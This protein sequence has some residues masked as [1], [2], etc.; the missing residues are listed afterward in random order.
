MAIGTISIQQSPVE[1]A[2]QIPALTNWTPVLPYTVRQTSITDLFYFKFILEIRLDDASGELLAK[3]KQRPNGYTT[4]TT[5]VYSVFNVG[6]IIN[7]QLENT[8]ADQND[9][10]KSIHTLGSNVAAEIFSHN[11][12]QLREVYVKAYQEYSTG[13]SVSPTENTS[14][15]ATNT[16]YYIAGTLPLET[17]RGTG[18]YFQGNAFQ[19]FQANDV[20]GKFLSDVQQSTGDV[21][22]SSVYRNYVQWDD[23]TNT[24]DFHTLGFLNSEATFN[25]DIQRMVVA[26][27]NS[28]GGLIDSGIIMNTNANG[29][30]DPATSGGEA[31]TNP[32]K[33][34]YFGCGPGNLQ[35]STVAPSGGSAGD[36]RPSNMS[37]WAYYTVQGFADLGQFRTALYY[38][39]KQDASCKGFKIRRLGWRNS[40]GCWDYFNFKMKSKQNVNVKRSTYGQALGEYNSTAYS[41]NN[42]DS[43]RKVNKTDAI[44]KETLNT[45]WITEQDAELLEKC[46]MS[47]DVFIIENADTTYTV[48]VLVTN[49]N[50]VRK[51]NVNNGI[52]IRYTINIEYSNPLNTNS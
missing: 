5:N 24:G 28:S 22:S 8:Y 42:F 26:Y 1:G 48:P 10:T 37:G 44:L 6:P 3:I 38:F 9:T 31:N 47:T 27:F 36:L 43:T 21:V 25:S 11:Q 35:A 30:A 12:N 39:I 15:N 52:K 7:T 19:S 23:S 16:K 29:G 13:A 20:N 49:K 45:D 2:A 40:L 41:Y 4:G 50:M 32:E 18:S 33:L 51:T 17:A 46:L 14:E 34:L